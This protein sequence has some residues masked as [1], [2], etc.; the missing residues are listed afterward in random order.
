MGC[1]DPWGTGR[2]RAYSW[3]AGGP[4]G[5]WSLRSACCINGNLTKKKYRVSPVPVGVCKLEYK[6]NWVLFNK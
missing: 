5:D 2:E 3:D 6:Y 4:F 1:E